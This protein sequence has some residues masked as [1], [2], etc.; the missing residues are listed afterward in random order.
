MSLPKSH[1]AVSPAPPQKF[2]LS[3]SVFA[4]VD[5]YKDNHSYYTFG[6]G[7]YFSPQQLFL[8]GPFISLQSHDQK[9]WWYISAG[10][11]FYDWETDGEDLY[12]VDPIDQLTA[13]DGKSGLGYSLEGE[14]HWLIGKQFEV[15][16]GF[17]W[18]DSP[19][20]Q[21]WQIGFSFRYFFEDHNRPLIRK[22]SLRDRF[23]R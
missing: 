2:L 15:G 4:Q 14:K 9:D 17:E 12:P 7:G 1:D 6:H 10:A 19:G 21:E 5:Q 13:N 23:N 11:S 22:H 20:Y 8:L 18:N 3:T 16:V